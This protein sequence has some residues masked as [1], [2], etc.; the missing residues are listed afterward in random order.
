[1]TYVSLWL[2]KKLDWERKWDENAAKIS[3]TLQAERAETG[4]NETRSSEK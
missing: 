4:I 3:S 1:L 2:G